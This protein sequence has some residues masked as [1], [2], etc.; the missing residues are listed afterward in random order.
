MSHGTASLC[1]FSALFDVSL[2][3]HNTSVSSSTVPPCQFL[4]FGPRNP[5]YLIIARMGGVLII[6]EIE[7]PKFLCTPAQTTYLNYFEFQPPK[8]PTPTHIYNFPPPKPV[9]KKFKKKKPKFHVYRIP[10]TPTHICNYLPK[11]VLEK[12]I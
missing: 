2:L 1:R 7:N 9:L 4:D 12:I 8:L 10:P 6:Q 3:R 5:T 11:P